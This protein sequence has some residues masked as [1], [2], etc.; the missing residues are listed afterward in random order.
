MN[1]SQ[2]SRRRL[3]RAALVLLLAAISLPR[4]AA[5]QAQYHVLEKGETLYS[6]ARAYGVKPDA[7]AKAN[8]ID[9]PQRLRAGTRLL[10]PGAGS[11]PA[12]STYKVVRGDTL[13]S[14]A[15]SLGVGLEALRT[16]NKLGAASVIKPGDILEIPAGGKAPATEAPAPSPTPNQA[17][18][19]AMPDPVRTSAKAVAKGLSWPCPGEILYL[20][21]KAYGVVIKAKLGEMERAVASG[22]VSSAGP[23]RGYGN[24]AFVLSRS[25][26][27]YVY[28]GLDA[29]SVRAGDR[30]AAGQ[31]L[32]SVG[33]DAKQ[34]GPA[35]YFLVF[36]NGEAVDPAEAPRD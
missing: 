31:A 33:M 28:G 30:V 26:Y 27:I 19:P 25:G 22:T 12:A 21:G 23:Y 2:V 29:I 20:D 3:S 10:I 17:P 14:I 13:Y 7:I 35:A 5:A 4:A 8:S 9:D 34:G 6:V 32:G 24:V 18:A 1:S 15:R 11:P 16:A 36:K